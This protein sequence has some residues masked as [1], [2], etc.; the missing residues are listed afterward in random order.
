MENASRMAITMVLDAARKPFKVGDEVKIKPQYQDS[1]DDKYV[2]KV[3]G[4]EE[5]GRVD[6]SPQIPGM[7]LLPVN[8]VTTDMIEHA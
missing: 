8:T 5:K 7:R 4:E 6:I 3:V 1:G 2:W